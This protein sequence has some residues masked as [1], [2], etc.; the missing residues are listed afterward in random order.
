MLG[1]LSG[2]ALRLP[3]CAAL[4]AA[5]RDLPGRPMLKDR[6]DIVR[7]ILEPVAVGMSMSVDQA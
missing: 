5:P 6:G 3:E 2:A 1:E 4:G 7:V